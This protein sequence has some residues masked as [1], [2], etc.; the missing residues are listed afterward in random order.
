MV[1]TTTITDHRIQDPDALSEAGDVRLQIGGHVLDMTDPLAPVPLAR[2]WVVI[3]EPAGRIL[4]R[5][6]SD[7]GGRFIF[8]RLQ[9]ATYRLRAGVPGRGM[10]DRLVDVPSPSGEYDLLFP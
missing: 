9:Q 1:V 4:A 10:Q 2:A 5:T 6:T 8:T 7:P 3:E